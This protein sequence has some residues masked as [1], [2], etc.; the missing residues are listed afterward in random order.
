M[1]THKKGPS[2]HIRG[3]GHNAEH[4]VEYESIYIQNAHKHQN[5]LCIEL[6]EIAMFLTIFDLQKQQF[7]W[8]NLIHMWYMFM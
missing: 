2:R 7:I 5:W 3:V 8:L 4:Y 6:Y 1:C